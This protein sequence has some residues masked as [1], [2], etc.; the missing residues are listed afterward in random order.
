MAKNGYPKNTKTR[1]SKTT[2]DELRQLF[3]DDEKNLYK[4]DQKLT[5]GISATRS[6]QMS[7]D[8]GRLNVIRD[9]SQKDAD[10]LVGFVE[11][12]EQRVAVSLKQASEQQNEPLLNLIDFY[13]EELQS[14]YYDS[15][16]NADSLIGGDKPLQKEYLPRLD[17][18]IKN[19]KSDKVLTQFKQTEPLLALA[20]KI[21]QK[22]TERTSRVGKLKDV[23]RRLVKSD[24]AAS[25]LAGAATKSP[26]AALAV[27]AYKNRPKKNEYARRADLRA[28]Q[29]DIEERQTQAQRGANDA[30]HQSDKATDKAI[31]RHKRK[32][33]EEVAESKNTAMMSS[34]D[35][36]NAT[37]TADDQ[38]A[39]SGR[40]GV[41][42]G[43]GKEDTGQIVKILNQHTSLLGKIYGVN[44]KALKIQEDQIAKQATAAEEKDLETQG[45]TASKL[46]GSGVSDEEKKE[47]G[48]LFSSLFNLATNFMGDKFGG[49][50]KL[51][52]GGK[53][54]LLRRVGGKALEVA[55]NSRVGKTATK[56]AEV[57]GEALGKVTGTASKLGGKLL[58]KGAEEAAMVA[59]KTAAKGAGK[60][61]L[62]AF[63]KKIVPKQVGKLAGKAVPFLGAGLAAGFTAWKL[64]QG[65]V[66]GAA[67]E[68]A[69][70]IPGAGIL[71][72]VASMARD[73]YHDYY[74]VQPEDDPEAGSRFTEV[75]DEVKSVANE[76]LEKLG[77]KGK[78]ENDQKE[79]KAQQEDAASQQQ[80]DQVDQQKN[81]KS[82]SPKP[83]AS[84][85]GEGTPSPSAPPAPTG[86]PTATAPKD[87]PPAKGGFFSRLAKGAL[88][89]LQ[90]TT[91]VGLAYTGAKM[92]YNSVRGTATKAQPIGSIDD[93]K[94][95]II[96]H[97]G[98]RYR[99]Y[100]DSLG[101]WTVGVGHLIGNGRSLPPDM[102][103]EFSHEEV[104]SMFNQDYEHHERAAQQIAGYG[105]LNTNGKAAL[106]DLTFNMG[107][108]WISKFPNTAKALAAGDTEGAA[109]GLENSL[110]YRQVG[111]R[112]PE[113]V[114]MIR[115][116]AGPEGQPATDTAGTTQEA[117]AAPAP[118]VGET[119]TGG[120]A[121]AA[122][123]GAPSAAMSGDVT[124]QG[125]AAAIRDLG[126]PSA[127][128]GGTAAGGGVT[129]IVQGGNTMMG[130]GG[131][132]NAAQ[133]IPAPIDREPT[134]RRILDGALS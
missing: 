102:N 25:V 62:T 47:G 111:N 13:R 127:P 90:Y 5:T 128:I 100:K 68:A 28:K 69:A 44:A 6:G 108:K 51:F 52:K 109:S 84:S 71:A 1:L 4:L 34:T 89:V 36:S 121:P 131:G 103:R 133:I 50:T 14:L 45:G 33:G 97:E 43:L 91:P 94:K 85:G 49:I 98:I 27:F 118:T 26:F 31:A 57:G 23:G 82:E 18:I 56:L 107:P 60:G 95:M 42:T 113:I 122:P 83:S 19:I 132:G 78:Q 75:K 119:P 106:V 74:G 30:Q 134:I 77:L 104:M 70:A 76:E 120:G 55:K 20:E 123:G 46:V 115:A 67:L 65:D 7:I 17:L 87:Q 92:L 86:A 96:R 58:G 29:Q 11:K 24:I 53:G 130:G 101:L 117:S 15:S 129:N 105:R 125:R 88:K 81:G 99:P 3:G 126:R 116:G 110:W 12:E 54:G 114:S 79:Q 61:A 72:A 37:S 9:L 66:K 59:G 93:T 40:T 39:V 16:Q 10:K 73:I 48:G 112:A 80:A 32:L 2:R 64:L 22:L 38:L 8:R 124:A 35:I 21:K 41:S 63:I